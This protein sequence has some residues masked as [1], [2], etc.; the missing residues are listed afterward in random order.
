M[1][2]KANDLI[3]FDYYLDLSR[4]SYLL[5]SLFDLELLIVRS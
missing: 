2:V 5:V 3:Y 1:E 4:F